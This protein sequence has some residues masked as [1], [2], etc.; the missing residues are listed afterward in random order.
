MLQKILEDK[1][2]LKPDDKDMIVMYHK[3]GYELNGETKQIDS[4]LVVKGDDQIYT[5][6]A[7]T[8]G[9]PL[10]ISV[11]KILNGEITTPGVQLPISKEVYNPILNELVEYGV[12]F[13]EKEVEFECYNPNFVAG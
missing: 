10:A 7:K 5:A 11:I 2:T 8:V 13:N 3:F 6:M 4:Q 12:I 9:L 1:W